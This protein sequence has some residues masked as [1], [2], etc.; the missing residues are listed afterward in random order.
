MNVRLQASVCLSVVMVLTL[1]LPVTGIAEAPSYSGPRF[2]GSLSQKYLGALEAVEKGLKQ[3]AEKARPAVVTVFV[4][5]K[6]SRS[7][8]FPFRFRLP[9]RQRKVRGLGSGVIIRSNGYIVTNHHVIKDM[10]DIKVLLPNEE[11]VDAKLVGADP[12]TDLAVLK[13]N[14]TNL[15]A[16]DFADSSKLEIGQWT[17]AIG[18][19]FSLQNSV[20]YGHVSALQRSIQATK[21]EN[22]VQTDAPINRGNSGGPLVNIRG[23][24]IGINTVIQSTSGGSQGVGFASAS[25]LVKRTVTDLI[26]HGQVRRAW[27][28]VSIQKLS[29]K[30]L[31]RHYGYDHG[32]LVA[33][34]RSGSFADE[35]GLQPGDL[36][37]ELNDKTIEGPADLQQSVIAH[38]I[39]ERVQ[40]AVVRAGSTKT[41]DVTLGQRP[42]NQRRASAESTG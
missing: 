31:Q 11:K 26:E 17:I 18:S 13:I 27:L 14:R 28:G 33:N 7:R 29:A 41:I 8:G 22:F 2:E 40:L 24:I 30:A 15:P 32:A 10:T 21:Y 25:N 6:V 35:A 38:D 34:V 42:G 39:G 19:P 36:I 37:I 1:F 4:E 12:K 23:E 5:K 9:R 3:A 20:S 16:L